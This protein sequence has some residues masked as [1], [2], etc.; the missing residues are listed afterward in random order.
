MNLSTLPS[1]GKPPYVVL[2]PMKKTYFSFRMLEKLFLRSDIPCIEIIGRLISLCETPRR[3]FRMLRFFL[4]KAKKRPIVERKVLDRIPRQQDCHTPLPNRWKDYVIY[5]EKLKANASDLGTRHKLS[6]KVGMSYAPISLS[7]ILKVD[8]L[9]IT[10]GYSGDANCIFMN[11]WSRDYQFG[12]THHV[13]ELPNGVAYA[14]HEKYVPRG[15]FNPSSKQTSLPLYQMVGHIITTLQFGWITSFTEFD[16]FLVMLK[17]IFIGGNKVSD[18]YPLR[19][20]D[21]LP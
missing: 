21:E 14:C 15:K 6:I 11:L 10:Y 17:C 9:M 16:S 3:K 19:R 12:K 1:K 13:I 18:N 20:F 8:D 7:H 2:F 4:K 5:S